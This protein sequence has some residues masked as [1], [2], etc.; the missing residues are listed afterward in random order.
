M[1]P[2]TYRVRIYSSNLNTVDGDEGD[3]YYKV[4]VWPS[5]YKERIVLKKH[6]FG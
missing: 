1:K 2:S 6:H 4:E 5:V 3:D